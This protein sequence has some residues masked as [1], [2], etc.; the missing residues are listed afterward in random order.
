MAFSSPAIS[1]AGEPDGIGRCL[2]PGGHALQFVE[3]LLQPP[4]GVKL[5]LQ[6]GT[7][8]EFDAA[9]E[10]ASRSQH[11]QRMRKERR[12]I[13]VGPPPVGGLRALEGNG[14]EGEAERDRDDGRQIAG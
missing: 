7:Q 6:C 4:V 1:I 10:T 12:R 11:R 3:R 8:L 2:G 5:A 13:G 14:G 9:I